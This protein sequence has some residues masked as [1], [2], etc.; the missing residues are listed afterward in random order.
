[1]LLKS[2]ANVRYLQSMQ[3]LAMRE[4]ACM[5]SALGVEAEPCIRDIEGVSFLSFDAEA[6]S[7]QAW[8]MLSSHSAVAF[9]ATEEQNLLHPVRLLPPSFLA[10]DLAQIPKYKGKT[11]V[12]FTMLLLNCARAASDFA[13]SQ[14]PL[15]VL[16]P[17]CGRGTT[18]LCA[19]TRGDHAVGMDADEKAIAECDAYLARYLQYHRLKHA[20]EKR[21]ITLPER[22]DAKEI[23]YELARDAQGYRQ[24]DRRS[25][26][27]IAGDFRR[28]ARAMP[29]QAAH[30]IVADLPYGVQHAP[31]KGARMSSL[32]T[33][34]QDLSAGAARLLKNGGAL[35][36][37]FN[38]YTLKRRTLET[39]VSDAGLHVLQDGPYADFSHWV[40]QAVQRDVVIAKR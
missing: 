12:E 28:V 3:K 21:S 34:A 40:E 18:L 10:D 14:E 22:G 8:R 37:S 2:H 36:L 9:A 25:L 13:L 20:R 1:M 32:E 39:A 6:L 24:G 19:L 15:T 33:L 27:L 38:E 30:L 17:L 11:N 5:L 4:C 35:A 23:W 16:D 7:P 31:M 29:R 26:R